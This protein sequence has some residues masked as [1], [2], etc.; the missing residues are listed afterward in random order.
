M[1][2]LLAGYVGYKPPSKAVPMEDG[3]VDSMLMDLMSLNGG[4]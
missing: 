1:H 3:V 4:G 2:V